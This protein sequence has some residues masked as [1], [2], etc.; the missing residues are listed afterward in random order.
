MTGT[1]RGP[2]LIPCPDGAKANNSNLLL[3]NSRISLPSQ[4][5]M[6]FELDHSWFD[7][8]KRVKWATVRSI[9]DSPMARHG[10]CPPEVSIALQVSSKVTPSLRILPF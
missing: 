6:C 9:S 5:R 3:Q 8:R 4:I 2:G 1:T 10:H 7:S